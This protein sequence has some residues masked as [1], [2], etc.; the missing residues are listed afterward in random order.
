MLREIRKSSGNGTGGSTVDKAFIEMIQKKLTTPVCLLLKK[1]NPVAYMDLRKDIEEAKKSVTTVESD[2]LEI[3]INYRVINSISKGYFHSSISNN[4]SDEIVDDNLQV[5][6]ATVQELFKHTTEEVLRAVDNALQFNGADKVTMI[7]LVGGFANCE[8]IELAIRN[9]FESRRVIVPSDASSAVLHG[10]VL[11]GHNP[12]I[13]CNRIMKCTYGVGV[14]LPF[15]DGIHDPSRRF[16][17]S[18]KVFCRKLFDIIVK[19]D[20]SVPSGTFISRDYVII[21]KANQHKSIIYISESLKPKYTDEENCQEICELVVDI[22]NTKDERRT[23]DVHFFF[24]GTQLTV[25]AVDRDS[26]MEFETTVSID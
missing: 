11:Y 5:Q 8:I 15:Q 16:E 4:I 22:P 1:E 3:P 26:G 13:I 7:I 24:G 20:Q 19:R 10:A 6:G 14:Q 9:R 17:Q 18:G 2:I 12:H 23:I 21:P 25:Q